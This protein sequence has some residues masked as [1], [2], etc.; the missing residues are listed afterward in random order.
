MADGSTIQA[1]FNVAHKNRFFMPNCQCRGILANERRWKGGKNL[2]AKTSCLLW[3]T[4]RRFRQKRTASLVN[5]AVLSLSI[6]HHNQPAHWQI[7]RQYGQLPAHRL[8]FIVSCRPFNSV[9]AI[10]AF[11]LTCHLRF[12]PTT[13]PSFAT[14]HSRKHIFGERNDVRV[15]SCCCETFQKNY[16]SEREN[17]LRCRHLVNRSQAYSLSTVHYRVQEW[18]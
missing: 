6:C 11:R 13:C 5:P 14:R 16:I 9:L 1:C 12:C 8:W 17:W 7:A 18:L 15:S 10:I 4:A 3:R 2:Q